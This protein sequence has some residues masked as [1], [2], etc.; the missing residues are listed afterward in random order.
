VIGARV[1]V[2]VKIAM[3]FTHQQTQFAKK[4]KEKG[5]ST[6]RIDVSWN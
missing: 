3:I 2:I 6:P 5:W 4:I 1:F